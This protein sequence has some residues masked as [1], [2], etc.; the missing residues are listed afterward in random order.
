MSTQS[1]PGG[2]ETCPV[3]HAGNLTKLGVNMDDWDYVVALAGNPNTGKSTEF[4]KLTACASTPETG[5]A[6]LWCARRVHS[7]IRT[8]A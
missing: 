3:H 7:S 8:I 5:R 4:N 6:R 2:C 1:G